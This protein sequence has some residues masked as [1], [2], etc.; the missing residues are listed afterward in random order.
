MFFPHRSTT[1]IVQHAAQKGLP[2][3]E[4]PFFISGN[5]HADGGEALINDTTI[6]EASSP[7]VSVG[8]T[9]NSRGLRG[10]RCASHAMATVSRCLIQSAVVSQSFTTNTF[11]C[12]CVPVCV[13]V[14]VCLCVCLCDIAVH[15]AR[16]PATATATLHFALV[17]QELAANPTQCTDMGTTGID[18]TIES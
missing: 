17:I 11:V 6:A 10:A 18:S 3:L 7:T 2:L 14:C 13:C 8:P 1:I 9:I 4:E 12:V 5:L 15:T 16:W